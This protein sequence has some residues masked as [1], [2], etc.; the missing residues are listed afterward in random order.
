MACGGHQLG[1][2]ERGA[3]TERASEQTPS[4]SPIVLNEVQWDVLEEDQDQDL[5]YFRSS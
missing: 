2:V 3:C 5:P 4:P 1:K